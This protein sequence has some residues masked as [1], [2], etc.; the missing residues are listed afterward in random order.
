MCDCS[1]QKQWEDLGRPMGQEFN[2]KAIT[3]TIALHE[4]C[5]SAS[6]QRKKDGCLA[7]GLARRIELAVFSGVSLLSESS[8]PSLPNHLVSSAFAFPEHSKK[9]SLGMLL[10]SLISPRAGPLAMLCSSGPSA[11]TGSQA[12]SCL[13]L[14]LSP[15]SLLLDR[16]TEQ[17][18]CLG[19]VWK[20]AGSFGAVKRSQ[21]F[22]LVRHSRPVCGLSVFWLEGW[23]WCLG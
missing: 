13:C 12:L 5:S 14:W 15:D 10:P 20:L 23:D 19:Y 6:R 1:P 17:A 7:Y 8:P 9:A 16:V 22:M 2:T 3:D 4:Y 21:S 11:L 18:C